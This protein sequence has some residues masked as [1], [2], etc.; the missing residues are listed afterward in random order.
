MSVS[1]VHLHLHSEFSLSDGIVR[2]KPLVKRAAESGMPA[3]ALTDMSNLFAMI[4]FYSAALA[5]GVKPIIG[6]E[7]WLR[8]DEI[9]QPFRALLLCQDLTGYRNLTRLVS[10][11]YDLLR[12]G[13]LGIELVERGHK[14]ISLCGSGVD[15]DPGLPPHVG[16]EVRLKGQVDVDGHPTVQYIVAAADLYLGIAEPI[17]T[18]GRCVRQLVPQVLGKLAV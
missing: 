9:E 16:G 2:I 13:S 10:L 11:G 14:P 18:I 6:A 7:L 17:H 12:A 4:K 8:R 3:V 1:F 5:A 15:A